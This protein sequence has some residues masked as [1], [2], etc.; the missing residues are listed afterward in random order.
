MPRPPRRAAWRCAA[1]AQRRRWLGPTHT[2]PSTRRAAAAPSRALPRSPHRRSQR[3]ALPLCA[4]APPAPFRAP[5]RARRCGGALA[6]ARRQWPPG[7]RAAR[8]PPGPA[9]APPARR[10]SCAR[11]PAARAPQAAKSLPSP[12]PRAAPPQSSGKSRGGRMPP[13][14]PAGARWPAAARARRPEKRGRS[15]G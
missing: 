9:A 3:R 14:L 1:Q 2:W 13:R 8:R 6:L 7:W 10:T 15:P 12:P 11:P 4:L 5:P